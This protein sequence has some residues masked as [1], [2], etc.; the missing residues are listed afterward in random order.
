MVGTNRKATNSI[1]LSAEYIEQ[2]REYAVLTSTRVH[3]FMKLIED[4]H[5]SFFNG[6]LQKTLGVLD[7]MYFLTKQGAKNLER[8]PYPSSLIE[9]RRLQNR[10]GVFHQALSYLSQAIYQALET[11]MTEQTYF[12]FLTME[13][14]QY[15]K[16]MISI[17]TLVEFLIESYFTEKL[18]K[19]TIIITTFGDVAGYHVFPLEE[20]FPRVAFVEIP[21]I[22]AYR[23][24]FW[25]WLGHE[26][27]HGRYR[28][29][30]ED[31][32]W[33]RAKS[34][35]YSDIKHLASRHWGAVSPLTSALAARQIEEIICDTAA[36][37]LLGPSYLLTLSTTHLNPRSEAR[38]FDEHPP[39]TA[40][41]HYLLRLLN[42]ICGPLDVLDEIEN[43]WDLELFSSFVSHREVKYIEEYEELLTHYEGILQQ[44]PSLYAPL[45]DERQ[46]N[47][48]RWRKMEKIYEDMK[49]GDTMR[50]HDL[51]CVDLLTIVWLKRVDYFKDIYKTEKF[52]NC[53]MTLCRFDEKVTNEV[54]RYIVEK[55]RNRNA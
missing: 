41:V 17:E 40:R 50:K 48:E 46:F 22:D 3:H 24:R 42:R 51:Q 47:R 9:A 19:E 23:C 15:T 35:I 13:P 16:T 12:K 34:E 2:I 29:G 44:L 10:L 43:S 32:N 7:S 27:F 14:H 26:A 39:M 28:L 49:G 54:I 21:K 38:S 37:R 6:N 25:S 55:R 18:L 8:L 1:F 5:D 45:I 52:K 20:V 11:D 33:V 30:V 36:A 53:F 31:E 4:R